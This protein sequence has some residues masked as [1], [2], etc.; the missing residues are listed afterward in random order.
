[1]RS[2]GP[3]PNDSIVGG[4][5]GRGHVQPI[6]LEHEHQ[7]RGRSAVQVALTRQKVLCLDGANLRQGRDRQR[8]SAAPSADPPIRSP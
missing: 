2:V 6:A 7:A 1:M 3:Q 5:L 4:I 8:I